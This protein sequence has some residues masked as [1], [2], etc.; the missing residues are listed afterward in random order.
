MASDDVWI[1]LGRG[2][3]PVPISGE[4]V[5]DK[6][7]WMV[8]IPEVEGVVLP[9]WKVEAE[10]TGRDCENTASQSMRISSEVVLEL[11]VAKPPA[12]FIDNA[13]ACLTKFSRMATRSFKTVFS[14]DTAEIRFSRSRDAMRSMTRGA[15]VAVRGVGVV[16]AGAGVGGLDFSSAFSFSSSSTLASRCAK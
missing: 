5:V 15:S 12:A 6:L 7:D 14:A 13:K 16:V 4:R 1:C 9:V 8:D 10:G 11:I 3:A 2:R